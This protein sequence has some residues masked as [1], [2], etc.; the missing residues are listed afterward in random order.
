MRE[1][2]GW[3]DVQSYLAQ[4]LRKRAFSEGFHFFQKVVDIPKAMC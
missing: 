3:E 1:A 4:L 2:L